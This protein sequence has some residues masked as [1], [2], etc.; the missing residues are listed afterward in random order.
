MKTRIL[1]ISTLIISALSCQTSTTTNVESSNHEQSSKTEKVTP[2]TLSEAEKAEGWKLLFDGKTTKGWRG[3]KKDAF[4]NFGWKVENGAMVVEYSGTGEEGHAGDIITEEQYE[5]FHFKVDWKISPGG[6]S[7][8]FYFVQEL[9]DYEAIWHTAPEM[10]VIDGFG[11]EDHH[12]WAIRLRQISGALYDLFAPEKAMSKPVGEWNTAE[13]VVKGSDV[14]HWLN[15]K[16][17]VKYQLGSEKLAK[18]IEGSKF[19]KYDAFMKA[20]KGHIGLQDHGEN[21][22]YRNIKIKIF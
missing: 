20:K 12:E 4:P 13:I 5:N 16:M 22:M 3:F 17:V 19:K 2:N 14:E 7:G 9:D 21:V 6:N 8:V 15:G 1:I 18:R 10:Q 11:Y